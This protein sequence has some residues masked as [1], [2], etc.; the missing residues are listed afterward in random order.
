VQAAG[1]ALAIVAAILLSQEPK[2]EVSQDSPAQ[3]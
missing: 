2:A 3:K 1:I